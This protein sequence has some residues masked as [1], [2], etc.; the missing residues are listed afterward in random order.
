[1][2]IERMIVLEG[3]VV[4]EGLITVEGLTRYLTDEMEGCLEVLEADNDEFE[5]RHLGSM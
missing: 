2:D 1:M 4:F 5:K 3:L